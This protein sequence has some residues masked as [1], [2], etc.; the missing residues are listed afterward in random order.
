MGGAVRGFNGHLTQRPVL[1]VER[2]FP[3]LLGVHLT[4]T[5]VTLH[6]DAA[7]GLAVASELRN[8]AVA[9]VVVAL[10]IYVAP[11]AGL[12]TLEDLTIDVRFHLRGSRAPA[13]D[14]VVII[15]IAAVGG[16]VALVLTA[17][18]H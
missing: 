14:R 2:R 15:G 11:F 17:L 4:Q 3:E 13:T 18:I 7:V 5:L 6:V 1:R 10:H 9:L 12:S 8:Q 16:L